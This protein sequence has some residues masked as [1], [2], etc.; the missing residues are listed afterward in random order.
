MVAREHPVA[1]HLAAEGGGVFV[2]ALQDRVY[3]GLAVLDVSGEL[4]REPSQ[5]DP[6]LLARDGDRGRAPSSP[7]R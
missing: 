2:I 1:D 6:A 3:L 7:F 4:A 5:Y